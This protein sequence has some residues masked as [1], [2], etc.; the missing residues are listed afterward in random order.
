MKKLTVL[1]VFIL[2]ILLSYFTA[3]AVNDYNLTQISD[4][5]DDSIFKCNLIIK[6]YDS[7]DRNQLINHIMEVAISN[8]LLIS[9]GWV[10]DESNTF[11]YY[12]TQEYVE[13]LLLNKVPRTNNNLIKLDDRELSLNSFSDGEYGKIYSVGGFPTHIQNFEFYSFDQVK[14]S[15][16]SLDSRIEVRSLY[17]SSNVDSA[18]HE[19]SSYY[20]ELEITYEI[21]EGTTGE[22]DFTWQKSISNYVVLSLVFVFLLIMISMLVIIKKQ[23]RL[24]AIS[25]L[26][27]HSSFQISLRLFSLFSVTLVFTFVFGLLFFDYFVIGKFDF[28]NLLY[29][30]MQLFI[31]FSFVIMV[32]LIFTL[33]IFFIQR[34]KV[35]ES[36]KTRTVDQKLLYGGLILKFLLVAVLLSSYI[37]IYH[38]FIS[39]TESFLF[40]QI[41]KDELSKISYISGSMEELIISDWKQISTNI[42][43]K[44]IEENIELYCIHYPETYVDNRNHMVNIISVNKAYVDR[45]LPSISN[46]LSAYNLNNHGVIFIPKLLENE[47]SQYE[48]FVPPPYLTDEIVI[49]DKIPDLFFYFSV[50]NNNDNTLLFVTEVANEYTGPKITYPCFILEEYKGSTSIIDSVINSNSINTMLVTKS[51]EPSV[52]R[53][54]TYN[55]SVLLENGVQAILS[56]GIIVSFFILML[57]IYLYTNLKL[58]VIKKNLG[59]SDFQ[60]FSSFLHLNSIIYV[61]GLIYFWYKGNLDWISFSLLVILVLME[62]C[63]IKFYLFINKKNFKKW[64]S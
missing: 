12:G 4:V 26:L 31:M 19:L 34:L 15:D 63:A 38:E 51:N 29:Y 1:F 16:I 17:G 30:Q 6:D 48:R 14:S 64:L 24:I 27:G 5:K 50:E 28:Y 44:F 61:S 54:I 3:I 49:L 40:Y 10:D 37:D 23:E 60:T 43:D 9:T 13:F 7:V 25:K 45:Y 21:R 36:I 62:I 56:F 55:T 35:V 59:Y 18:I 41:N 22:L 39:S 53:E 20:P 42:A 32:L 57:I 46:N 2:S 58:I 33:S 11:Y 8:D 47:I 52:F